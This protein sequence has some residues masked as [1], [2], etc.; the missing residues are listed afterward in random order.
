MQEDLD[1][2]INPYTDFGFKKIFGEETN[3]DLLIDFLNALLGEE[4]KISNVTFL[5]NEHLGQQE[6]DRKAIFDIFCENEKGDNFIVEMQKA[7]Q[8]YFKD[9]ALYYTSVM[10]QNQAQKDN[11][12]KNFVW[13]FKLKSVFTISVMDFRFDENKKYK[14]KHDVMLK[15]TQDNSLFYEKLRMIFLE[16]PNFT[17]KLHELETKEDKWFYFLKNLPMLKDIPANFQE[18]IF[19]KAFEIAKISKFTP[20]EME[21]YQESLKNYRDMHNVIKTAKIEG[22]MEGKIEG[23]MEGKI[24]GKMEG[25]KKAL[26]RGKLTIQ[27]IAE[28]F[29]VSIDFVLDIQKKLL[30]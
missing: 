28:D 9:R 26:Q 29:E 12:K 8:E 2:F 24:E 19:L 14:I 5:K 18:K 7:K 16:M 10:I 25:I 27:E 21:T 20:Q 6:S 11:K 30:S 1:V 22:I 13:D 15:D 4:I 23:I 3:K 17:K